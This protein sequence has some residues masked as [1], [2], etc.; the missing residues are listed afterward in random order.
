MQCGKVTVP[1]DYARPGTGTLDLALARYRG[2]G[3]PHHS[4]LLNFGGPGGAGV[5]ELA[6][7]GQQ[8]MGLTNGYDVVTFD[9]RGVGRS[10]P[11]AAATAATRPRPS[12]A[13]TPTSPIPRRCCG[14]CGRARPRA[15]AAPVTCCR[16]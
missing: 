13:P 6:Y 8:F 7:D 15:R 5:N 11:S 10:S 16:T 9:P 1:L 12:P 3:T 14:S 2:T 4:V